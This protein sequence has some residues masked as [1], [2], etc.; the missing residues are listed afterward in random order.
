MAIFIF[1]VETATGA[2][3]LPKVPRMA[4]AR[5]YFVVVS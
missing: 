4:L 2:V 3:R 5:V 1:V